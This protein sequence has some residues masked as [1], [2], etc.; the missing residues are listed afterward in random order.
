MRERLLQYLACP[1]CGG[2]LA[3]NATER[4]A[5]HVVTGTLRCDECRAEFPVRRGVPRF[6]GSVA[7]LEEKTAAAFG[8]EWTRYAE[9]ADRYRQQFFDWIR[10][11]TPAFLADRAVLEGGCGKGR[12]TSVVA[13]SGARDVVAIDLGEAVES[14]FANTRDLPNAH[15][16]QGDIK[17]PPVKPVFD[18]A[19]SVGVLH[20]LPVPEDGFHALVSRLRP[21]GH[22]S[23]WVY[24]REGN[25]W[26]VHIVSPL[27][28]HVT[29]R[30]PHGILDAMSALLTVP[31]FLATRLL[32]GPTGGKLLGLRL[33][34][35]EYL[36][37]IAPFPYR[38]QR[39][40]VFDHLVA[41]VAYY[42]P[43]EEFAAWF[44]RAGLESPSIEHHNANSWRGFAARPATRAEPVRTGT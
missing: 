11:V 30:M 9:L 25:G 26:I 8:Y 6:A 39:S 18:Y 40:I 14:A 1:D 44:E 7:A 27:R 12:H 37:Y 24:G 29:S 41:P 28:Q 33:P 20:H 13:E 5:V 3:L 43:R 23:A 2:D 16:V 32:Y 35:G 31:L 10:P 36:S 38:E 21:G 22:I 17:R 4:D 42:I 34:Y 19:F 15:I